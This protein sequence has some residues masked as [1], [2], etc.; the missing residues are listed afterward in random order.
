MNHIAI[1]GIIFQTYS[2]QW[3]FCP[4]GLTWRTFSQSAEIADVILIIHWN[5][6]DE[7][8]VILCKF[9]FPQWSFT[10]G[11]FG[12]LRSYVPYS[13][14]FPPTLGIHTDRFSAQLLL[15]WLKW[16]LAAACILTQGVCEG[17]CKNQMI[18]DVNQSIFWSSNF[19]K[20]GSEGACHCVSIACCSDFLSISK[21]HLAN[22]KEPLSNI[23]EPLSNIKGPLRISKGH[24][25]YQRVT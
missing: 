10:T 22:I 20:F 6:W 16:Q 14:S 3:V 2:N 9:M 24:L 1:S 5:T 17:L 8:T 4:L 19:E 12:A 25:G 7:S 15:R 23:K 11:S 21:G 18:F 13:V